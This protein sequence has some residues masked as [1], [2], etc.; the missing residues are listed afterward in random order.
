MHDAVIIGAGPGG[1]STAHFLSRRGLDVVLLDRADFPRDKTCGDGLT[2]RALR[3][4][5]EMGVLP[6][7]ERAGCRVGAYEVVAPNGR[8]T[9]AD[10][11]AEHGALV[12]P[13]RDLDDIVVRR[14]AESGAAFAS[15]V[16]VSHVEPT[17]SGVRVHAEGGGTFDGRV[18]IIATGAATAVLKRSGILHRQPRAMLAA[19]AYFEDI[20]HE[21][22]STFSL[23]F[24]GV[25]QPGYGWVFPVSPSAANIGVGFLPSRRTS[26]PTRPAARVF[27]DF[28]QDLQPFLQ[29]ARQAGP[30]KGYPI[31]VDFLTAPTYAARTLLVGEAAGLVNPLTGE[32]ID[33]ALES[34]RLAADH[35]AAAFDAG[36]GADWLPAYDRLLRAR[37]EKIFRFSQLVRDWYCIPA[38]LNLLVPL[39]N[40]RPALRQLLTNIVLGEREPAGYGPLT[41]LARLV[42]YLVRT[43][44][45]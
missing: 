5:D 9:S 35:L 22:A 14:A 23:R 7:V 13:R 20:Q 28:T 30:V 19:R 45:R 36:F 34:G 29:G 11:T 38:L 43:H 6:E 1:S 21:V 41:M 42:V 25:P 32:G 27:E 40:R 18:A 10:I 33:Y 24:H 16:T 12:V 37:F 4:L 2:P 39:A 26:R 44:R 8:A 17:S 3:V 31:R 15:Q